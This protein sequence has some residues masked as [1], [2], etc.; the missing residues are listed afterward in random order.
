MVDRATNESSSSEP[1]LAQAQLMKIRVDSSRARET[2]RAEKSS[3]NS[4]H[5]YSS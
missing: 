4:A 5:Y 2:L 1:G 3:P